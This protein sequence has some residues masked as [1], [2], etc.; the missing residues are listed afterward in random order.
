MSKDCDCTTCVFCFLFH[1]QIFKQF[2]TN[3]VLTNPFQRRFF[4][5]ND[6]YE[7]FS[8]DDIGPMQS[9]E[10]GTI[11][12]GTGSEIRMRSKKKKSPPRV[13]SDSSKACKPSHNADATV[14][15]NRSNGNSSLGQRDND[16]RF[17]NKKDTKLSK[18]KNNMK[19]KKKRRRRKSVE[20]DGGKVDNVDKIEVFK[21][22]EEEDEQDGDEDGEQKGKSKPSEDDVLMSLFRSSGIHSALRHDK[23]EQSGNPDYVL[24]EKEAERVAKQAITALRQSRVQCR[25]NGY[26]VPTWTGRTAE[27]SSP[28]PMNRKRFGRRT[29]NED[30]VAPILSKRFGRQPNNEADSTNPTGP[31]IKKEE[32]T[33]MT[34]QPDSRSGGLDL[35]NESIDISSSSLLARMRCRNAVVVNSSAATSQN[36]PQSVEGRLL[37]DIEQFV[38]SRPGNTASSN[39]LTDRFKDDLKPGQ[40]ALFKEL[41]KQLCSLT[42]NN[43]VGYWKVKEEF[44]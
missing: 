34:S 17:L 26:S 21:K 20:I 28:A 15:D 37:K 5:S 23:I 36:S 38:K 27:S 8:L 4:K 30:V 39:E 16:K 3:R 12:A 18:E 41:L 31:K 13:D 14:L 11:F 10:T 40:N 6:L 19:K 43:G 1:R 33:T 9:T 42:K 22:D 32:H 24:V 44:L 25:A 29:E 2:L 7:L 35:D